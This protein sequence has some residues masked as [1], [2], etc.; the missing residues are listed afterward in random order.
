MHH[1]NN[2]PSQE[3]YTIIVDDDHDDCALFQDCFQHLNWHHQVK[4]FTDA[5]SLLALLDATPDERLLPTLI[6]LDYNLPRLAGEK[7][8]MLLK[9]DKRYKQ[10]PIVMYSISMTDQKEIQLRELG[11]NRCRQKPV[12]IDGMHKFTAELIELSQTTH[13]VYPQKELHSQY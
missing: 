4:T 12:T 5:E 10:I 13:C 6:V 7:A 3:A 2:N 11:A 1:L 9:K 8:L